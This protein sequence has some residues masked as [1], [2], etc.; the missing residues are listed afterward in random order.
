MADDVL[1]EG[2]G[3]EAA[4]GERADISSLEQSVSDMEGS[5]TRPGFRLADSH[6]HA[7]IVTAS[8]SPRLEEVVAQARG[9]FFVPTDALAFEEQIEV[10][11]QGH[12]EVLSAVIA[13]DAEAART[14][15]GDHIED[16]RVH[17]HRVLKGKS[18]R[19]TVRRRR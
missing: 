19:G 15:M 16:T 18:L 11:V 10:S 5:S 12:E 1:T 7:G 2:L 9:E 13:K 8:R 6:F 17:F 4:P 14:A 3:D